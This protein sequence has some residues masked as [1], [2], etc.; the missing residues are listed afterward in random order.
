MKKRLII[1]L[2]LLT[3]CRNNRAYACSRY[4]NDDSITIDIG[5]VND[6]ILSFHVREAFKLPY[7]V[8]YDE[9]NRSLL[10]SQLNDSYHYE[11][12]YLVREY[13]LFPDRDCSLQLTLDDLQGRRYFCE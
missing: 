2:I 9:K 6:T 11:N 7:T 12:N 10:N 3:G 4:S 8:L 1:L 13:D 5:A